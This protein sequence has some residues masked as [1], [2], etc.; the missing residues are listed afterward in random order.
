[1]SV[2]RVETTLAKDETLTLTNL[3]FHVG[4]TVEVLSCLGHKS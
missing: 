3:P 1:M 2:H 4:D